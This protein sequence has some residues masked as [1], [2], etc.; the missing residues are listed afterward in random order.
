MGLASWIAVRKLD[1]G[2]LFSAPIKYENEKAEIVPT[3]P[4]DW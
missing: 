2:Q 3:P 4:I 1:F